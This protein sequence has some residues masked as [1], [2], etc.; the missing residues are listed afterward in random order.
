VRIALFIILLAVR[1]CHAEE[2]SKGWSD[3]LEEGKALRN[4]GNYFAAARAFREAL[5]IAVRSDATDWQLV[6]LHHALAGAYA[7]TGQFLESEGEYRCALALVKKTEGQVSLNYAVL[8][9]GMATLPTQTGNC[10][11]VIALLRE[12]IAANVRIGHVEN[13]TLIRECLAQILQKERR[14]QEEE[15][16]LLDALADLTKQKEANP[17]LMGAA[18]NNLA[19]LRFDQERY[20]ES[21][22]LHEK[23]IRVFEIASE[24]E[25]HR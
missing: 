9:A 11:E 15:P 19:V 17:A 10:E 6:D 5:A 1:N 24:K 4:T 2:P 3:W 21:I 23:S 25:H 12:A 16:L 18:L 22:N 20:E 13:I 7:E 14:Y 8:L